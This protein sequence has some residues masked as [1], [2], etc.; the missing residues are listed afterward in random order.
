MRD[1]KVVRRLV[2]AYTPNRDLE[3]AWKRAFGVV[4][5]LDSTI[6]DMEKRL[7]DLQRNRD[8]I[9]TPLNAMRETLTRVMRGVEEPDKKALV[10]L[11]RQ[12]QKV[13]DRVVDFDERNRMQDDLD[14]II[15][16]LSKLP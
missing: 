2:A 14:E 15:L 13:V 1:A 9:A 3:N 7:V 5:H 12:A 8:G 4:Q 11:V 16:K 10:G 6:S